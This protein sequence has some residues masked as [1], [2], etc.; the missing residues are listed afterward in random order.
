MVM[1]KDAGVKRFGICILPALNPSQCVFRPT[2]INARHGCGASSNKS[3]ARASLSK[4]RHY[5]VTTTSITIIARN[6]TTNTTMQAIHHM[7]PTVSVQYSQQSSGSLP[8]IYA[9]LSITLIMILIIFMVWLLK[10][11]AHPPTTTY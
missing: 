9:V 10:R 3:M 5:M 11:H 2:V 8:I 7:V 1:P 6:S 4:I